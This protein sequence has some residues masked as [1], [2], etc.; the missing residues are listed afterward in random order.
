M[1]RI[2]LIIFII[3]FFAYPCH[4]SQPKRD[5]KNGNILYEKGEYAKALEQYED[6]LASSPDSDIVN[7]NVGAALYKTEDHEA[8]IGHFEKSLVSEDEFLEQRASYNI[9]NAK[10]KYGISMEE[11]DLQQA[12]ALL[13]QSLRHYE[14]TLELDQED[15]DAIYNYEFVKAELERLKKQMEQQQSQ[16]Q[17]KESENSEQEQSEEQQQRGEEEEEQGEEEGQEASAAEEQG[18]EEGQSQQAQAEEA[19][20]EISEK[21]AKMLLES[22]G[23]EEEPKGLYTE[24]IPQRGTREVLKDW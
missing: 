24:K 19:P 10:Y 23:E 4:A 1:K 5:V 17:D 22:Y 8:A 2:L 15:E 14:R 16:S 6:A 21:E 13:E 9:G 11:S 7:Y 12:V 3:S 18:E 20:E